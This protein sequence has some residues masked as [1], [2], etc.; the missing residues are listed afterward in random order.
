MDA[1]L[2][3]QLRIRQLVEDY[4]LAADNG[5]GAKDC[6]MFTSTGRMHIHMDPILPDGCTTTPETDLFAGVV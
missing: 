2:I 4:A 3:A 6:T 1:D 5:D